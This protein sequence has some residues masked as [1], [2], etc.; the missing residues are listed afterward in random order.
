MRHGTRPNLLH[1]IRYGY[2]LN[3]TLRTH[4]QRIGSILQHIPEHQIFNTAL[5]IFFGNIYTLE[6]RHTQTLGPGFDGFDLL[7]AEPAG[8]HRK[9]MDLE[10][11][12]LPEIDSAI[13]SVQSAAI[14]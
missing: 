4:T 2:G 11:L 8:I 9:G 1:M 10:I 5:V 7:L 12:H 14:G 3:H 13:R 6:R